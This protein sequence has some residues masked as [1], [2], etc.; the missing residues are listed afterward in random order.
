MEY[1]EGTTTDRNRRP[2]MSDKTTTRPAEG[3]PGESIPPDAP[4]QI[5]RYKV[6]RELGGGAF[7]RVYLAFDPEI[8][9]HVA[10]KTPLVAPES[11]RAF[12]RE[13]RATA[14]IHHENICPVYDV[15][16]Q[17]DVPFIVM[18]FVR[19]GTLNDLVN[20]T[21][22]SPADA[23]RFVEQIANGLEAAHI[24]GVVHRDLK[25]ANVLYDEAA[26]RL[27]L[28]DFGLARWLDSSA[29]TTGGIK[30]TPY[31]MAPEQ[32][33]PGGPFGDV[34]P[35]T[36]VYSLG[37]VL[38]RLLTGVMPFN[39]TVYELMGLHCQ[40]PAQ[41]PSAVRADLDPR[42]DALCLKALAKQPGERY[43]SARAFTNAIAN[44]TRAPAVP[45]PVLPK[46]TVRT[47][48]ETVEVPLPRGLKFWQRELKM[49]FCWVPPGACRL[50]SPPAEQ[51]TVA[52]QTGDVEDWL[53]AESTA[54]RGAYTSKGFWLSKY[55]VTQAEWT[56]IT[57]EAPSQ[58]RR[59]GACE[60]FV[61][62]LDTARFP[63]ESV[64]WDMI[65]EPGG[66]LE[67]LNAL[68]SAERVFGKVGPF[69]LPHE[70]AWEYA[71]RGADNQ[72]PFYWG[73]ALD[74][75]QANI[76]GASPFGTRAPGPNLKRPTTVGSFAAKFPHPWGLCDMI[77][78][79]WE[80][81][82]NAHET[83]NGRVLRGGSWNSNGRSSRASSRYWFAPAIKR[84]YF[85]FRVFV[86]VL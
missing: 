47:P 24:R 73:P 5:G 50:G 76:N 61:K 46:P 82:A 79:V 13:A 69:G 14:D 41:A 77:G 7:G 17:N 59:G 31:Y 23:L 81:C 53:A 1:V 3:N 29:V 40:T 38:F 83:T 4:P 19:G 71:C 51:N 70:D 64:S 56:A 43:E 63:V 45:P 52:E 6:E 32:W 84:N 18:R 33:A 10:I 37:V 16:A 78:N 75:T 85:G 27:L 30:G 86:P 72:Q 34:S 54:R 2:I 36:D 67:K 55:P 48:G 66:F 35:R 22:P 9:R 74:G 57:G 8:E 65:C 28:T 21:P 80:W 42:L 68:G 39:G 25:P 58:F 44:Y 26:G 60:E 12:L 15:G 49:V 20:R 11:H 62:G